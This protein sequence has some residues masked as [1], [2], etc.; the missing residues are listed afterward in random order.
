MPEADVIH[1]DAMPNT[2]ETLAADLR[3]CGLAAGQSVIVHTA[4]SK[5]GWIA[6]GA[7]AVIQALLNVLGPEGT[8]MMPTHTTNNTDPAMWQFPPVPEHWVPIIREQTPAYD[9]AITPTRE[10]GAVA[11]LFRTW[12]GVIRSSHPITSFAALGR[13]AGFLI[14]DHALT[15][16]TGEQSPIAR[17]YDLDGYVLLIGVNHFNNTSLHLAEE[18]TDYPGKGWFT[19]GTAMLV[20]GQRQWVTFQTFD[21]YADDFGAIGD[22]FDAAHN[23]KMCK[24]GQADTRFFRQRAVIDFAK[25]WIEKHRDLSAEKASGA[26]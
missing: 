11:E 17:L 24:V 6:G 20:D 1:D 12:P 15:S 7:Q 13:H 26:G 5:I 22:A 25:E 23:V 21:S 9:P 14:N 8:L 16:E 4:M 10:M 19:Q 18:R 3:R 2:I